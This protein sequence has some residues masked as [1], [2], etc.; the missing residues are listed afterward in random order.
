VPE[1]HASR[2]NKNGRFA[3]PQSIVFRGEIDPPYGQK[4][5]QVEPAS[6][7][8]GSKIVRDVPVLADRRRRRGGTSGGRRPVTPA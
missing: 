8:W 3:Q 4:N 2:P 1:S 7:A 5:T 6:F